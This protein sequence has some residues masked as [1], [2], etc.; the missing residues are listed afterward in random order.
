MQFRLA[1][2]TDLAELATLFCETVQH[3][4]PQYYT[5]EQTQAWASTALDWDRF[6]KT[7]F[8]VTTYVACD[9][10]DILGFAGLGQDGWIASV[11]VRHDRLGQGI[12]SALMTQILAQ[13]QRDRLPR[14]YGEA[15]EFSVGLFTKFGFQQYDIEMVERNGVTFTRY[16]MEKTDL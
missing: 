4:A 11:Y 9:D 2:A 14:L 3:H 8:S 13:A 7:L 12:G 1:K 15:S 10:T 6:Q 5:D 16:L